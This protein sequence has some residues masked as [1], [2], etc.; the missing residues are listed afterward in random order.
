[1]VSALRWVLL[2]PALRLGSLPVPAPEVRFRRR[3]LVAPIL[4]G[5]A[6]VIIVVAALAGAGVYG[7]E[8]S[9]AARIAVAAVAG[10][11]TPGVEAVRFVLFHTR[12][13]EA[14]VAAGA[15]PEQA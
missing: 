15:Q 7:W 9:E 2:G 13:Y 3:D 4:S 11:P 8:A 14:F 10:H 12:M 5:A 6:L 1:M